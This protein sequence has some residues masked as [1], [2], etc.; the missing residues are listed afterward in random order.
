MTATTSAST[1]SALGPLTTLFEPPQT[2]TLYGSMVGTIG[3]YQAQGCGPS[4]NLIDEAQCWPRVTTLQTPHPPFLGRGFYSPGTIC[5][6]GYT[7]VCSSS[8]ASSGQPPAVATTGSDFFSFQFPL[9]AGEGAVGCCP[10]GFTC[11]SI[12]GFAQTCQ[13]TATATQ[14][15]AGD[16]TTGTLEDF[17]Q[18]VV[19]TV[20]AFDS[21]PSQTITEAL[22]LA[23]LFQL[24]FQASDLPATT[25]SSAATTTSSSTTST[26]TSTTSITIDANGS[27]QS[28][29]SPGLSVR[30][31]AAIGVVIPLFLIA[32]AAI[33][34]FLFVRRRRRQQQEQ[35]YDAVPTGFQKAELDGADRRRGGV[36]TGLPKDTTFRAELD[37]GSRNDA[38]MGPYESDAR[39]IHES[40]SRDIRIG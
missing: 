3:G 37:Q 9:I 25:T 33:L 39:S 5:P 32:L 29:P 15:L 36:K 22:L 24:N 30:A 13:S 23:P 1:R 27:N 35:H 7:V 21:G 20:T 26:P 16:C 34:G 2:C 17:K 40:G 6:A 38:I 10:T 28:A 18:L 19:P 14:L 12:S 11:N 4:D 8:S 31:I